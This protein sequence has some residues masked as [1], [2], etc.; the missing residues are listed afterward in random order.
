[1]QAIRDH[2]RAV[3]SGIGLGLGALLTGLGYTQVHK[4]FPLPAGHSYLAVAAVLCS[5]AALVGAAALVGLFY[6]AQRRIPVST[7]VDEA[8]KSGRS[9]NG[10]TRDECS[11]RNG[12]FD[13]D[14]RDEGAETL[15]ALE[16]RAYRLARIGR[17]VGGDRGTALIEESDRLLRAV[18]DALDGG[19]AAVLERRAEQ[20]FK[21]TGTWVRVVLT[22]AGIIGIFGLADWA[23]GQR[24]LVS[25]GKECGEAKAPI[26]ACDRFGG[27]APPAAAAAAATPPWLNGYREVASATKI[28]ASRV[29]GGG[30]ARK[31]VWVTTTPVRNE[32]AARIALAL[33]GKNAARCVVRVTIPVGTALRVGHV[34]PAFG[35]P[36][37]GAQLEILGGLDTVG[38]GPDEALQP[39]RRP[40]P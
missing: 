3:A 38:F 12:V 27:G 1:M 2:L 22:I 28:V 39:S 18:D 36:G 25:L 34:G 30:A 13:Q 4:L 33:P 10:L 24:D 37:G 20:A 32:G 17:R 40:C 5:V 23:Q 11:R 16:L 8:T 7:D 21:S 14:A 9:P 35:H 26:A 6:A 15:K 19:A 29:Y 31:G